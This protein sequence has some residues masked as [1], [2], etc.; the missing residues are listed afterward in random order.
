MADQCL[1]QVTQPLTLRKKLMAMTDVEFNEYEQK[2]EEAQ[3][4]INAAEFQKHLMLVP[5]N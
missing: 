3:S 4:R 2:L 5:E 1:P